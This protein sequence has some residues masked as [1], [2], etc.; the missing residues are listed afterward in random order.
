MGSPRLSSGPLEMAGVEPPALAVQPDPALVLDQRAAGITRRIALGA[1]PEKIRDA[2]VWL[3][4]RLASTPRQKRYIRYGA[5][6]V[7]FQ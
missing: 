4:L 5:T 2:I 1:P 6:I 3:D 7:I